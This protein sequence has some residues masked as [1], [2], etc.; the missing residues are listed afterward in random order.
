MNAR[1]LFIGMI[2]LFSLTGG[3]ASIKAT[4]VKVTGEAHG[5]CTAISG[6]DCAAVARSS[7]SEFL[8]IPVSVMGLVAYVFFLIAAFVYAFR[9]S[10]TVLN[11]MT[12]AAALGF[13]FSLYL[14][15]IEA[16]VLYAWCLYCI[17]SQISI[18]LILVAVIGLR[19]VG[20]KKEVTLTE[21]H[22]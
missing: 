19:K 7:Y 4:E 18:F 3:Y 6:F 13:L 2:V 9:S 15:S 12:F 8:G 21:I 11:A 20:Q 14:T 1:K 10:E 5:I 16:F 22:Q 17:I